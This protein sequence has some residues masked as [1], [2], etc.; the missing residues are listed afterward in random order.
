MHEM[1]TATDEAAAA[2]QRVCLSAVCNAPEICKNGWTDRRRIW[3]GDLGDQGTFYKM[4]LSIN[5]PTVR[6]SV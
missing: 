3:G 6:G 1:R 4:G 2:S 5:T